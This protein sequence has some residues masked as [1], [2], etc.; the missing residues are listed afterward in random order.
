VGVFHVA[1]GNLDDIDLSGVNLA[2]INHF[3]S[4]LSSGG[5][6]FGVLVD[7]SASDEQANAIEKI[8][9]GDE[10]GPFA[11]FAALTDDWAGMERASI[12]FSDGD[13]PTASIRGVDFGFDPLPGP[14]GSDTQTTVRN[15]AFGFAPEFKVGKSSGHFENFGIEFD[16]NY[17]ETA[18]YEFASEMEEGAAVGR[19]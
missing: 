12:S 8:I 18:D 3:P 2:L 5:W 16:G 7:E 10:G 1:D 4:N 9:K 17:G 6:K 15:A 14:E 13:S 19:A 11:Q